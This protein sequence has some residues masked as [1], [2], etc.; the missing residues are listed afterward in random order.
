MLQENSSGSS[1]DPRDFGAG[2]A[3]RATLDESLVDSGLLHQIQREFQWHKLN[4]PSFVDNIAR[5]RTT[6][7]FHQALK[8]I[9]AACLAGPLAEI[10]YATPVVSNSK[11]R[12][13]LT[14]V[15]SHLVFC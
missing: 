1:R 2:F 10:F 7:L 15:D 12:A 3:I 13:A 8:R 9:K 5:V 4:I 6:A 14:T 11:L